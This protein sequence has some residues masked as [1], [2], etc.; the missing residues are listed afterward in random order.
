MEIS[1]AVDDLASG[2]SCNLT[3]ERSDLIIAGGSMLWGRSNAYFDATIG[4]SI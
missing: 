4:G 3:N 2:R 1:L